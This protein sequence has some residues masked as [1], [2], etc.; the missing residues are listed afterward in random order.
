MNDQF[1]INFQ[2]YEFYKL[3]TQFSFARLYCFV[4]FW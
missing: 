3:L 4:Y 2:L 1:F